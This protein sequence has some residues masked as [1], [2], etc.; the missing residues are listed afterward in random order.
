MKHFSLK[1]GQFLLLSLLSLFILS[2][3]SC[4][5]DCPDE[6]SDLTIQNQWRQS[7]YVEVYTGGNITHNTSLNWGEEVT[8]RVN[9][10]KI[11]VRTR[12]KG[13]ILFPDRESTTVEVTGCWNYDVIA[14]TDPNNS[15]RHYLETNHVPR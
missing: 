2:A 9:T 15:D 11:E 7:I 8:F 5:T 4:T 14:Y 10:Q 1:Y 12:E 6:F 3:S 13:F